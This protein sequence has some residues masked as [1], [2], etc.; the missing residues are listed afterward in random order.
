MLT[1]L[2]LQRPAILWGTGSFDRSIGTRGG[3]ASTYSEVAGSNSSSAY[4]LEISAQSVQM[5]RQALLGSSSSE[6]ERNQSEPDKGSQNDSTNVRS[7][8]KTSDSRSVNGERELSEE[9]QRKVDELAKIHQHVQKHE[10]AH[11]AA[12]G[13]YARGGAQYEYV[14]GPDGKRYAVAGHVNMD[15]SRESEPQDTLQKANVVRKAALAPSDPSASDRQIAAAMSKMAEEART[16]IRNENLE[17]AR[18]QPSKGPSSDVSK[19]DVETSSQNSNAPD[20]PVGESEVSRLSKNREMTAIAA[21]GSD[22]RKAAPGSLI[23]LLA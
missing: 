1:E 14:S 12:A 13:G 4:S 20:S 15:T 2:L 11:L 18:T 9:D 22:L 3:S 5:A 6:S 23:S 7:A 19:E 10:Q 8:V 16:E 21:Y 17:S